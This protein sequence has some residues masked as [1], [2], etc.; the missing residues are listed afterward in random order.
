M[1]T[2]HLEIFAN[3]LDYNSI[4]LLRNFSKDLNG[5]LDYRI[6]PNIGGSFFV[7]LFLSYFKFNSFS[8]R[9]EFEKYDL[10]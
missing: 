5:L 2:L 9:P 1:E 4:Y 6:I 8:G 7:S 10:N 3:T